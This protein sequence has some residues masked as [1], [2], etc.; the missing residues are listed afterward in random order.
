MEHK[1]TQT[2]ET[3]RLI[4]RRFHENE[5]EVMFRNWESDDK[6]TEFLR[7]KTVTDIET[8]EKALQDWIWGINI[9]SSL[10]T[11]LMLHFFMVSR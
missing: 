8:A 7:W 4:L 2:I 1:G 9:M 5:A 6:V 11:F 3:E 10:Q